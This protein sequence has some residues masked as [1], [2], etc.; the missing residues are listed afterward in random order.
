MASTG[1]D[2]FAF[3]HRLTRLRAARRHQIHKPAVRHQVKKSALGAPTSS[4]FP[5]RRRLNGGRAPVDVVDEP[6]LNP[7]TDRL[8]SSP[9]GPGAN[10]LNLSTGRS[11]LLSGVA[12][13]RC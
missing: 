6:G 10:S 3:H 5:A 12:D 7:S 8:R 11:R 1:I 9:L 2:A 4:D 13:S